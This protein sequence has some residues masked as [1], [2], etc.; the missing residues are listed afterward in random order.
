MQNNTQATFRFRAEC[1]TDAQAIRATLKPW[2]FSWNESRDY[3]EH[4]GVKYPVPDVTVV[5]CM[6]ISYVV[7]PESI[8]FCKPAT[9]D[10]ESRG[11]QD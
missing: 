3:L 6:R 2:L 1:S 5:E 11:L 4:L 7:D 9:R 8:G 10:D